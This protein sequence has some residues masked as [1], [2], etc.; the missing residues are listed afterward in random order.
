MRTFTA[1][2]VASG[3]LAA[4]HVTCAGAEDASEWMRDAHSAIRLLAGSRAGNVL[5]G[6]VEVQLENGWKTYWRTP[7]DSV[8]PPRF[9]FSRSDNVE[10]VTILF[11]APMAFNDGGGGVS[12]GY[13]KHVV[14]PLRIVPKDTSKPVTL[15]GELNYAV[16][17]KLCLPVE[18]R[19][20]IAFTNSAS[21]QD[22]VLTAALNSLPKPAQIGDGGSLAL[23][24]VVREDRRVI[25]DVL[26]SDPKQQAARVSL[27]AEGPTPDW[28]LP[29]PKAAPPSPAGEVRFAFELDGLPPGAKSD[30]A[31]LKL[32]LVGADEAYEY[33]VTLD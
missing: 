7:G 6:G 15:R 24:R 26:V 12:F 27:F 2:L 17:Q 9:D 3:V 22:G 11:P 5:L 18:A 16:C 28:A 33:N 10:K 19:A 21:T 25:A 20:E 13:D 30:G 4:S 29:V 1:A 8:V 14:L 31:T 32:T 23:R